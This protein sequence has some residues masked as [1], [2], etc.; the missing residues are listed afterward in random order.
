[1]LELL[2]VGESGSGGRLSR[3]GGGGGEAAD[4]LDPTEPG[5]AAESRVCSVALLLAASR[6]SREGRTLSRGLPKPSMRSLLF[7]RCVW[8]TTLG[9]SYRS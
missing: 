5:A 1:M 6:S 4:E 9:G 2:L 3:T 7:L 8:L